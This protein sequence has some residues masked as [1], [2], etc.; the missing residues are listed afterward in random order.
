MKSVGRIVEEQFQK[1]QA[2]KLKENI[3]H[4]LPVI[5]VSREPGSGG[6]LIAKM[7]AERCGLDLFHQEVIHQMATSS[8]VS[9]RIVESLDEKGLSMLYDW[10]NAAVLEHHL[11]PDEYLQHLMKVIGTIGKHGNA[12]VVGRGANFILPPEGR[13]RVRVI[14]S[15][16]SRIENVIRDFGVSKTE[17]RNRIIRTESNRRAFIQKYFN[18]DIADAIHYDMILN[19]DTLHLETAVETIMTSLKWNSR[20]SRTRYDKV[21]V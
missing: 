18:A 4:P 20:S 5:T 2:Q 9:E 6:Q 15:R 1:W 13:L 19:T 17:A 8:R 14:A 3:P 12:V 21:A 11:W 7:L 16:A 10:I